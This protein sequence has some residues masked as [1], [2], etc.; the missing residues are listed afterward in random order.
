MMANRRSEQERKEPLIYL[1]HRDENGKPLER[2]PEVVYHLWPG[3]LPVSE[4]ERGRVP[5]LTEETN[6]PLSL[7]PP[8][9]S[10]D[11]PPPQPN[12]RQPV[13]TIEPDESTTSKIFRGSGR[14]EI[15]IEIQ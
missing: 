13:V 5:Q 1:A 11:D 9:E 3:L 15:F 7:P 2:K 14:S 10:I 8:G 4:A 6:T 12:K